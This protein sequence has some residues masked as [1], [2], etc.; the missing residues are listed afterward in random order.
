MYIYICIYDSIIMAFPANFWCFIPFFF[1]A[2]PCLFQGSGIVVHPWLFKRRTRMAPMSWIRIWE[3]LETDGFEPENV[4]YIPNEIAIFHRDNDQQNHWA[5][6]YNG[7]HN[8]FRPK[9]M[10]VSNES[11]R[12]PSKL[13]PVTQ[14]PPFCGLKMKPLGYS[15]LQNEILWPQL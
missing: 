2:S 9:W 8:I 12:Y 1:A 11:L 15:Y 6:G 5:I 14:W 7:L 13:P 4:G 10:C 3:S